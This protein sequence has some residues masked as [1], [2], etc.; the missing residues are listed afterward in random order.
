MNVYNVT[1]F[2]I[3]VILFL[4]CYFRLN[5]KALKITF[6]FCPMLVLLAC[7]GNNVGTDTYMYISLFDSLSSC[8]ISYDN[9]AMVEPSFIFIV[10]MLRGT[11]VAAVQDSV[12]PLPSGLLRRTTEQSMCYQGRILVPDL[13]L[14]FQ[15]IQQ[16]IQSRKIVN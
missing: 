3:V 7:R 11:E 12:F 13:R 16:S 2:I 6:S 14:H 15:S 9:W 8:E 10:R 1:F 4:F 5:S